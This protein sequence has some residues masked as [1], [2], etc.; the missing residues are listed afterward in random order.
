MFGGC[1]VHEMKERERKKKQNIL[2]S[3]GSRNDLNELLGNDGLASSV[4]GQGQLVNH[5]SWW[6]R[7]IQDHNWEINYKMF[8]K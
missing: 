7:K 5:L 3:S 1:W 4:E 8:D 2:Q 6:K